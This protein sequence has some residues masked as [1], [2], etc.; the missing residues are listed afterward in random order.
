MTATVSN[1]DPALKNL[2]RDAL[3]HKSTFKDRPIFGL[4]KKFEGFTGRNM[5]MLAIYGNPQGR[6]ATF[7]EA[8]GNVSGTKMEDFLLDIVNDY[9]IA[10]VTGE[11]IARTRSDKGAFLAALKKHIDFAMDGLADALET[12]LPRSGTGSIGQVSSGSTVTNQTITLE[13]IND[14]ANFE[15]AMT[16]RGTSTDGGAYDLGEEVLAGVNRSTGVL[17][18]TSA[19]WNTVMTNLAASDY[20]VV[21]GDAQNAASAPIKIRGFQAWLPTATPTAAESFFGVDRSVDSRLFGTYHDGSAQTMEDCLIDGQS[22]SAQ[23]GGSPTLGLVN[24][25]AQRRL[26]KELGANK[27]YCTVNANG[28]KGIVANVGYR[29]VYIQGDKDVIKVVAANKMP[30]TMGVLLEEE[31]AALFS[32]GR[33]IQFLDDDGAGRVL[34]LGSSDGVEARLVFRGN[35]SLKNPIGSVRCLLPS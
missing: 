27:E 16:L 15:V 21:S 18:A 24:H 10:H 35:F 20:L 26:I 22:K 29:G 31:N 32:I 14:V 5:P 13:D 28:P 34:R 33:A 3:V 8:Q 6:S 1:W 23:Q 11:T 7:S 25:V 4:L 17:T 30:S 2:Y 9:A 12:F 19:A